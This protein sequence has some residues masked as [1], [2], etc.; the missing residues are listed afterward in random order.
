MLKDV[1]V[2]MRKINNY[3]Q[4]DI[5]DKLNVSRQAV[6]RWEAG[7]SV[8]D[9][10]NCQELCKIYDISIEALLEADKN[11]DKMLAPINKYM[12][13][14]VKVEENGVIRLSKECLKI[15]NLHKGDLLLCLGDTEQG[16]ALVDAANYEHFANEV[17]EAKKHYET[18][19]N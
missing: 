6:S 18:N 3:T 2:K 10:Y 13:G 9:I 16:I 11:D 4:E 7:S 1:L 12:F 8:P 5:A 14:Y 17:L 19:N 15:M